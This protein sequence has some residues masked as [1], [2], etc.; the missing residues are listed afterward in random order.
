MN[1]DGGQFAYLAGIAF[2]GMSGYG[3]I[4]EILVEYLEAEDSFD[5]TDEELDEITS[6][7][8]DAHVDD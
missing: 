6:M 1:G 5:L 7:L 2:D 8:R 3:S 4:V